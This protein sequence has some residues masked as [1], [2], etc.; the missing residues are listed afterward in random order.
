VLYF[1]VDLMLEQYQWV[2][3]SPDSTRLV[4]GGGSDEM[5]LVTNPVYVYDA[6]SGEELLKIF[7]HT[8]Q[9]SGVDWSPDGKRIVSGSTDDTTRIWDA[10]TGAELLTLPTPGDWW[11]IPH[12]SPDGKYLLVSYLNMISPGRSGVWRVWQS[13][14]ELVDYAKECCVIRELTAAE[15]TQFGLK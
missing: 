6:S 15:R 2:R 12:W 5:G 7:G 1:D 4:I 8:S 13:T 11:T 3:W 14:Q 10:Q 9:V